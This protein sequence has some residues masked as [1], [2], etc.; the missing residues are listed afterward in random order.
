VYP[1][2][3]LESLG[4]HAHLASAVAPFVAAVALRFLLGESRFTTWFV[5]LSTMWFAINVLVAPYSPGT[6][7]EVE[8]LRALFR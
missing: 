1:A 7:R 8:S 5:S 2:G 4:L 3:I 6:Q